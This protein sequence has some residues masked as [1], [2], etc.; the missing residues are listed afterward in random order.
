M[1]N[2]SKNA[3]QRHKVETK[4]TG[5]KMLK[6]FNAKSRKTYQTKGDIGD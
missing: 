3:G 4:D 6:L 1:Y 5:Q 2:M